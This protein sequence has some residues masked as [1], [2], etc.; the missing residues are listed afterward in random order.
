[1]NN[2]TNAGPVLPDLPS[3]EWGLWKD[4]PYAGRYES[5]MEGYEEDQML[6]YG[7]QCWNACDEQVAGPLRQR[8]AELER[9]NEALLADVA[10]LGNGLRRLVLA[11]AHAASDPLYAASYAET[12]RLLEVM[13]PKIDAVRGRGRGD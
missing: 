11:I 9:E 3:T 6:A 10:T 12:S 5:S 7:R 2:D 4:I 8:I 1:M 13:G